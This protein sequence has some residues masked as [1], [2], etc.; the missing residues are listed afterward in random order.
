MF[1]EIQIIVES[2]IISFR[3]VL[4]RKILFV[5]SPMLGNAPF[6]NSKDKLDYILS[7]KMLYFHTKSTPTKLQVK[8]TVY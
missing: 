3:I 1:F 7:F 6:V 5:A 4:T 8:T 2:S